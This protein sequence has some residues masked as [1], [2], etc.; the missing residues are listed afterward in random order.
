MTFNLKFKK[1]FTDARSYRQIINIIISAVAKTGAIICSFLFVPLCLNFLDVK[2]YGIWLTMTSVVSWIS[3]LDG[4]LGNGLK[5]KLS[6]AIAHNKM[7]HCK[8]LITSAYAGIFFIVLISTLSFLISA[9]FVNYARIFKASEETSGEIN[10]AFLVV[11]IFFCVKLLLDLLNS[12]LLALQKVWLVNIIGLFTNLLLLAGVYFITKNVHDNKLYYLS[13]C[14][15]VL[16]V[17]VLIICTFIFFATKNK[18]LAPHY[19]YYDYNILKEILSLG[20]KFF[21]IQIAVIIIFSTD[22][23][24][25]TRLFNPSEVTVYNIAF[26]YFSIFTF[27]WSIIIAPYWVAFNEAYVK[28]D[29]DWIRKTIRLLLKL[30]ILLLVGVLL[31]LFMSKYAY[32]FWVGPKV[33]VPF[34]LSI[35]MGVFV[36]ISTFSN[37][38]VYF[39]NGIGKVKIQFIAS[40]IAGLINL[41]LTYFFAIVVNMGIS[42]IIMGTCLSLIAG[43][44]LGYIQ[45]KLIITKTA[46]GIWLK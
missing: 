25:I 24:I 27:G 5:N 11:F 7:E 39:I 2:S 23:L 38:F 35:L 20:A 17:I 34:L 44:L 18:D 28:N 26:K 22:N 8:K 45:Y 14:F 42:G 30:W 9:R 10:A 6:E 41:P 29:F 16:P 21:V 3:F 12:I 13:L 19:R 15:S 31:F 32:A 37:I 36:L 4:G 46:K 40:L 1:N 43:P 33:R